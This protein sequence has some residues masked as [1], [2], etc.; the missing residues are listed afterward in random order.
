MKKALLLTFFALITSQYTLAMEKE[1]PIQQTDQPDLF[2]QLPK[3]LHK[4]F[5]VNM[6]G[7]Q[8]SAIE[9]LKTLQKLMLTSKQKAQ[10]KNLFANQK[11]VVDF[12]F[13]L[14]NSTGNIF[15][16]LHLL[17]VYKFITDQQYLELYDQ[18]KKQYPDEFEKHQKDEKEFIE[19][20]VNFHIDEKP[21]SADL[22]Q[23]WINKGINVNIQGNFG[24]TALILAVIAGRIEAVKLLLAAPGIDVNIKSDYRMSALNYAADKM[25]NEI[26][27]LLLKSPGVDVNI[28]NQQGETALIWAV[29][30][31]NTKFLELL[32]SIPGIDVNIQDNEGNTALIYAVWNNLLN[33]TKLLLAMPDIDVNIKNNNNKTALDLAANAE[34]KKMLQ[35]FILKKN[36]KLIEKAYLYFKEWSRKY[37]PF[38][39]GK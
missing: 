14:K 25:H 4:E 21:Y 15:R 1:T 26:E 23:Q 3:E 18:F 28:Q 37:L 33:V 7:T 35:E 5:V 30:R 8:P 17:K 16:S 36:E 24:N 9:N 10:L 20:F 11:N 2:A 39:R 12:C 22:L 32:L 13:A 29:L 34:I 27:E 38:W 31:L 19:K 6:L